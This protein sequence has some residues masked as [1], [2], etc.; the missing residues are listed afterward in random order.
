MGQQLPVHRAFH[1]MKYHHQQD[2]L[3]PTHTDPKNIKHTLIQWKWQLAYIMLL[4]LL[5]FNFSW[6]A[7]CCIWTVSGNYNTVWKYGHTRH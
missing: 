2:F 1:D 6:C 7:H 3:L 5:I 4:Y